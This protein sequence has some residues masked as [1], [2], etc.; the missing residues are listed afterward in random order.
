MANSQLFKQI[1]TDFFERD[2]SRV[3]HRDIQIPHDVNKVVSVIGPRRAGKTSLLFHLIHKLRESVSTERLVYVNFEDDRLFPI[4][5]KDMDTLLSAYY[6][7]FPEHKNHT[8]WFFFDEI[9]EVPNWELFIRRINDTENCRIYLTGS[10]AKLLSRE[11]ATSLRGRTLVYEIFTLTFSEFLRFNEVY[12]DQN[13]SKGKA[14]MLYWFDQWLSQGGFPELVFLP[15]DLHK[16]T[17]QEYTDLMLYRDIVE[18]FSLKNPS[19]LKFVFKFVV[20]NMANPL[21]INKIFNDLSSQGFA[22]SRSTLYDYFSY[23]EETFTVFKVDKWHRSVRVQA[24]N[25]SKYYLV[26]PAFKYS[27][28]STKDD[29]RV[30]ENTVFMH[31]KNQGIHPNYLLNKQE[32]DFYWEGGT[33]TNVCFDI[34]DPMTRSR[35]VNG[36][37]EALEKLG[38]SEGVIIT[39][40][41]EEK[42]VISG[43]VI[44]VVACWRWMLGK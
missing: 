39:R 22:I 10:S 33:P 14:T 37:V 31:F 19:L 7:L 41:Q 44:K 16:R 42:I 25:P 29:G 21:S 23:L 13:T 40:D 30:L 34:S 1:F 17:I 38:L 43:K 9:Q 8:V 5:L 20:Q 35:E 32:V 36:M 27:M 24:V 4:E 2:L 18:R 11:L 28:T 15:S 3:K 6:E 12:I 26:D